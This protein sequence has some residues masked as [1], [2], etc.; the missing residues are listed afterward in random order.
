MWNETC[1][2]HKNVLLY[3]GAGGHVIDYGLINETDYGE[4]NGVNGPDS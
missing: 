1:R 2:F 4:D 3:A